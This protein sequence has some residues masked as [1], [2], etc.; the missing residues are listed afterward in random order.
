MF[1]RQQMP[2]IPAPTMTALHP[3]VYLPFHLAGHHMLARTLSNKHLTYPAHLCFAVMQYLVEH[4]SAEFPSIAALNGA[5]VAI[6]IFVTTPLFYYNAY[7]KTTGPKS[8]VLAGVGVFLLALPVFKGLELGFP[9]DDPLEQ[10]AANLEPVHSY[11]HLVLHLVIFFNG[12]MT[13]F[14]VPWDPEKMAARAGAVPSSPKHRTLNT[15]SAHKM[16]A[17]EACSPKLN[18][19]SA[20]AAWPKPKAA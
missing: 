16:V 18:V 9:K 3:L 10:A 20:E 7:K 17:Q 12:L 14:Y 6:T 8:L 1:G 11:W 15:S 13:T 5:L 4:Y 2:V 19:K